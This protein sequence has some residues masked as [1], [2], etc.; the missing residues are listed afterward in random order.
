MDK[1][2][3]NHKTE[4][5]IGQTLYKQGQLYESKKEFG[6]AESNYSRI[7]S[8]YKNSILIDDA[9]FALAELYANQLSI[10]DKAQALFEHIIF[11]FED[12]IFFIEA[13]KKYRALRGDVIN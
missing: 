10:P 5:I 11:N 1:I 3:E 6:K 8:N 13:R 12:S 4:S 9:Y 2:L 7:I